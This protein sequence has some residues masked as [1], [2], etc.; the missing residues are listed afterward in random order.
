MERFRN[1]IIKLWSVCT[2]IALIKRTFRKKIRRHHFVVYVLIYA[3]L[4]FGGNRTNSLWVL[5]FYSVRF[6]WKNWFKKTALN[7]SIRR[8]TF[9]SVQNLKPPFL[10]QYLIF[11]N[12]F[13]FYFRDFIGNLK[14]MVDLKYC[15]VTLN[16]G[17]CTGLRSLK[18][19]N[20]LTV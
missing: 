17:Y 9:T 6:K 7:M 14:K 20:S 5:A 11:F 15:T 10:C 8:V 3:L 18:F 12:D 1:S 19:E 13:F 4:K 2:K 16:F